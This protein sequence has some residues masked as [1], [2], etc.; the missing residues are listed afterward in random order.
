MEFSAFSTTPKNPSQ[1]LNKLK[2]SIHKFNILRILLKTV[3]NCD[4]SKKMGKVYTYV[5]KI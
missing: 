4:L 1:F 5:E 2:R 3:K